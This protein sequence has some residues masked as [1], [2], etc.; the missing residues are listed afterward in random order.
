MLTAGE[1]TD[2]ATVCVVGE[3]RLVRARGLEPPILSEPDPKS[4]ASAI[5]PRAQPVSSCAVRPGISSP[6]LTG[7]FTRN[8]PPSAARDCTRR[9][10]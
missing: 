7:N 3:R 4:G 10:I 1:C 6:V 9:A 5:P 8:I 2:S